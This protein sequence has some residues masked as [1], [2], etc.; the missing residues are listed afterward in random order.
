MLAI[1]VTAL[2]TPSSSLEIRE[3][4]DDSKAGNFFKKIGKMIG[5]RDV[6]LDAR[7][8]EL[9]AELEARDEVFL[10]ARSPEAAKG[11][12]KGKGSGVGKAFAH[13]VGQGAAE[14]AMNAAVGRRDDDMRLPVSVTRRPFYDFKFPKH[15][16]SPN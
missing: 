15:H 9:L 1:S 14:A 5:F 4:D 6:H 7:D 3:D 16:T 2:P 12:G 11:R 8:E 10:N 13:G